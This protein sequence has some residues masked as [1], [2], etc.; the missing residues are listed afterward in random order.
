ML[1][2]GVEMSAEVSEKHQ[3]ANGPVLDVAAIQ[4]VANPAQTAGDS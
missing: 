3:E 4:L 1:L 2:M